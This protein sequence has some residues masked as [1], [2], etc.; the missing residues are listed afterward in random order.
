MMRKH[1]TKQRPTR[2]VRRRVPEMW[3]ATVREHVLCVSERAE[4]AERAVHAPSDFW[5]FV[6]IA[7]VVGY[8]LGSFHG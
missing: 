8:V 4:R 5:P 3:R 7:L 2:T 6:F 1:L